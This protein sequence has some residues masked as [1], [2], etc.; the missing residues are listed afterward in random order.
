MH[1][2]AFSGTKKPRKIIGRQAQKNIKKNIREAASIR[3]AAIAFDKTTLSID[4][5]KQF[6]HLRSLFKNLSPALCKYF[7][8]ERRALFVLLSTQL[9]DCSMAYDKW[10]LTFM[11]Y[12]VKIGPLQLGELARA[13][14]DKS[15]YWV[16]QK[17]A[18][19]RRRTRSEAYKAKRP[20][21]IRPSRPHADKSPHV[22]LPSASSGLPDE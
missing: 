19:D 14:A 11:R 21:T 12:L 22:L 6:T 5:R 17:W 4:D 13:N 15:L 7:F 3:E 18:E 20:K 10:T 8:L 9:D 1:K 2:K 16:V